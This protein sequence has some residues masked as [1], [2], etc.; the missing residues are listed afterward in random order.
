VIFEGTN[1]V[2]QDLEHGRHHRLFEVL[3]IVR[4]NDSQAVTARVNFVGMLNR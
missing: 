4:A 3:R 2:R 1:A